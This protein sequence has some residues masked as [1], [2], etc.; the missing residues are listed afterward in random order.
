M[1]GASAVIKQQWPAASRRSCRDEH[2]GCHS[3]SV[4]GVMSTPAARPTQADTTNDV[5]Q[6]R[7]A[8]PVPS[9]SVQGVSSTTAPLM[10]A[11]VLL[12]CNP[13]KA[14]VSIEYSLGRRC[15]QTSPPAQGPVQQHHD[16]RCPTTQPAAQRAMHCHSYCCTACSCFLAVKQLPASSRN[17]HGCECMAPHD[18]DS[19]SAVLPPPA[20]R[21]VCG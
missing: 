20:G 15:A 13:L 17:Q 4:A 1:Q 18:G 12:F 19:C 5:S 16:S 6:M 3:V 11:I 10:E 8:A 9:T 7:V 21:N 2:E 14:R